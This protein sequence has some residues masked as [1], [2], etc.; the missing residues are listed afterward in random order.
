MNNEELA[1]ACGIHA[2]D[3]HLRN[4]NYNRELDISGSFEEEIYYLNKVIPLFSKVFNVNIKGRTFPK[5]GTYGFI[6]R[7]KK[8]IEKMHEL[9]FP[10]GRKSNIVSAPEFVMKTSNIRIKS[11]FLR[12]LFDTDGSVYFLRS[13]GKKYCE[14]KRNFNYYPVINITTTSKSLFEDTKRLLDEVG[15]DYSYD[16]RKQTNPKW[17]DAHRIW[18]KGERVVEWMEKVGINNPIKSSRYE[19]WKKYGHCPS[20][21]TYSERLS[22][23]RNE[24]RLDIGPVWQPALNVL[25]QD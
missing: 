5:R 8:T 6:I 25:V 19:I 21:T 7:D 23:L 1:E 22:I 16:V 10:Y 3:G 18:I 14:F 17:A 15:F 20:N 11:A 24:I 9:G 12:G 4:K 13:R 2:G